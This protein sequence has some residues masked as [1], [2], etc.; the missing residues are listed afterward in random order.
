LKC[1]HCYAESSKNGRNLSLADMLPV[2]DQCAEAG[3]FEIALGGGE[4]TLHPELEKILGSI[5]E[6]GIVPNLATNGRELKLKTA[7]MLAKYV[8]AAALS[9]EFTGEDFI[10]R[11]GFAF[12]EWLASAAKLKAS[13]VRLVFQLTVSAANLDNLPAI[14]ERLAVLEPYAVIILTYKP[15]G[16]GRDFDAPLSSVS[17][18]KYQGTLKEVFEKLDGRTRVGYDCCLAN[19]LIGW[20]LS[21][22]DEIQGCSALRSSMAVDINLNA[23]PCSFSRSSIGNFKDANLIEIWNGAGADKFRER[24]SKKI[25]EDPLC[26]DCAY[27]PNCLGGCPEFEL[28]GCFKKSSLQID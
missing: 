13:G 2:F 28:V 8:G 21:G 10:K 5:R 14:A 12:S 4:P 22:D 18:K 3:V 9:V 6:R 1:P 20:G 7:K 25:I 24:F 15:A 26:K 11:R 23:F 16:R 19:A 17:F 27:K